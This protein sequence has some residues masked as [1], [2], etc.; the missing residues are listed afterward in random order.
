[1]ATLNTSKSTQT[2]VQSNDPT[3]INGSL[4]KKGNEQETKTLEIY[5]NRSW[6]CTLVCVLFDGFISVSIPI[7][8]CFLLGFYLTQYFLDLDISKI[9]GGIEVKI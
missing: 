6:I 3:L 1:M 9:I 4:K 7:L 8:F 5:I 2:S